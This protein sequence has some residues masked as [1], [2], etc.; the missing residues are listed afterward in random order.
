MYPHAVVGRSFR[1]VRKRWM[2]KEGQGV[3]SNWASSTRAALCL[4]FSR[5]LREDKNS[6]RVQT[7]AGSA[8]RITVLPFWAAA[9]AERRVLSSPPPACCAG[10]LTQ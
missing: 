3:Q 6:R 8:R 5:A 2:V 1:R 9:D 10:I 7:E 4:F